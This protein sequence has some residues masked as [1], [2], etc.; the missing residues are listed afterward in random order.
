MRRFQEINQGTALLVVFLA[1]ACSHQDEKA[2]DFGACNNPELTAYD[3]LLILAPHPDDEI[4]GFAGL[5]NAY[6]QEG[7]PVRTVVVTDGDAYCNACTLWTTGSID[8]GTC[9]ALT[10]SN[11]GTSA[12]D[13]FAEA[14]RAESTAA[15][16]VLGRSAP[17]FLAYP[18]T[19]LGVARA[20]FEA[21]D[22]AKLLR[23]SDFSNCATCDECANGYGAGPV[24]QL[25]A[26]TLIASLDQMIGDITRNTLIATT[27]WLDSHPDHAALGAFVSERVAA[28]NDGRTIAYSVIHANS[29]KDYAFPECWY[30]GPA[31][32]TCPCRND[33]RAE[34]DAS[35]LASLRAHRER[36]DWPQVLPD[37]V[38]YGEPLQLCLDD[39]TRVAK[40]RAIDAFETQLGT[41]GR[42]PG[43][44]P[45]SRKGLLDCS[46]YLR[47]FGRRTEVFVVKRILN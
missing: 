12:I 16:A 9:D 38:D 17:E 42:E 22:A 3:G 46:G 40:P 23:R 5:A 4:V 34:H 30:P 8:G 15:A 35:W 28:V 6:I 33:E 44:L 20:N 1:A 36:P 29:S 24:T 7:K 43:V 13:S 10:L 18:D 41:V 25:N 27:H 14:R 31:A 26:R 39:A 21:G 2:P 37:D 32:D 47:S 11:L 45:E 19:G